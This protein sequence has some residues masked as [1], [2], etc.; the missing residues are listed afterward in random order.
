MQS[1]I[2]VLLRQDSCCACFN[3]P[4]GARCRWLIPLGSTLLGL[5]ALALLTVRTGLA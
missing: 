5:G 4:G 2:V 3:D 1:K